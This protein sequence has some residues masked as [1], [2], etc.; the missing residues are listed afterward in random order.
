MF[1]DKYISFSNSPGLL[2]LV[3]APIVVDQTD[4]P[5]VHI[6]AR[7]PAEVFARVR[8][9][10]ISPLQVLTAEHNGF[11]NETDA[12]IIVGSVKAS[13]MVRHLRRMENLILAGFEGSGSHIP[14]P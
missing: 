7:N 12:A 11:V 8:K 3:G 10:P 6:A 2:S 13:P 4:F 1:D 14:P 5:G 9:G